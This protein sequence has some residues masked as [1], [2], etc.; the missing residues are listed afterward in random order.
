MQPSAF[1]PLSAHILFISIQVIR[2]DSLPN[3]IEKQAEDPLPSGGGIYAVPT[4][5]ELEAK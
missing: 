1:N 3:I 4:A 2:P 5:I